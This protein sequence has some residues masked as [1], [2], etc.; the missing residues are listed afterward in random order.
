MLRIEHLPFLS[1]C[2]L[3]SPAL[4]FQR[5]NSNCF[6][7][8][9][10]LSFTDSIIVS[11]IPTALLHSFVCILVSLND[12]Q[13]LV[14]KSRE[15]QV[16]LLVVLWYCLSVLLKYGFIEL[17]EDNLKQTTNDKG[18]IRRK[19]TKQSFQYKYV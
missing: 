8:C 13:I 18:F 3:D 16:A 19:F 1:M 15:D 2:R 6:S 12:L 9:L 10:L 4:Q 14:L 17:R 5:S 7:H 11:A